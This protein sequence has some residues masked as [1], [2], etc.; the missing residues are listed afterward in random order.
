MRKWLSLMI[1]NSYCL[2]SGILSSHAM[3]PEFVRWRCSMKLCLII[4]QVK[5]MPNSWTVC[6][7]IRLPFVLSSSSHK[8]HTRLSQSW[9]A[10]FCHVLENVSSPSSGPPAILLLPL[11]L[12]CAPLCRT[13]SSLSLSLLS[14]RIISPDFERQAQFLMPILQSKFFSIESLSCLLCHVSSD[15]LFPLCPSPDPG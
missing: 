5:R 4:C 7:C 12:P 8:C 1:A 10:I 13:V 6:L 9:S 3:I 2:T 11:L 15:L 14:P